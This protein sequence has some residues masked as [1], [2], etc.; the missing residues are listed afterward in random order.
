M[1]C[2]RIHIAGMVF[3]T[4]YSYH[5]KAK[6]CLLG[7]DSTVYYENEF[8]VG[9]IAT[10]SEMKMKKFP[11]FCRVG[12]LLVMFTNTEIFEMPC[13]VFSSFEIVDEQPKIASETEIKQRSNNK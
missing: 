3:K 6:V 9:I 13:Q 8:T 1:H 4:E 11:D 5:L 2:Y 12:Y 7:I 10:G